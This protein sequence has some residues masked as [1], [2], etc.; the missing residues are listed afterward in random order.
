MLP[1][2]ATGIAFSSREGANPPQLVVEFGGAVAGAASQCSRGRPCRAQPRS[3]DTGRHAGYRTLSPMPTAT[4]SPMPSNSSPAAVSTAADTDGDGL[5]DLWEIEAGLS[6]TDATGA[7]GAAG[8]P[9]GDGIANLAEQWDGT[10]PFNPADQ[11]PARGSL[12][13]FLPLVSHD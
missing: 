1:L 11:P 10:D 12:P 2:S 6:P 7:N 3:G 4:A 8:D 13:L 5:F 9:D